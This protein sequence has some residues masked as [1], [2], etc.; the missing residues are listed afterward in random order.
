MTRTLCLWILIVF[1]CSLSGS[2]QTPRTYELFVPSNDYREADRLFQLGSF[3]KARALFTRIAQENPGTT[4]AAESLFQVA[5]INAWAYRSRPDAI[6]TYQRVIQQF[7]LSRFEIRARRYIVNANF[8]FQ[9]EPDLWL[10]KLDEIVARFGAPTIREITR[11]RSYEN[12]SERIAGLPSEIQLGLLSVYTAAEGTCGFGLQRYDE[13][14]ALGLFIRQSFTVDDDNRYRATAL[15][16]L[17]LA[18]MNKNFGS[19]VRTQVPIINP[20]IERRRPR[21]GHRISSRRPKFWVIITDG[22]YLQPQVDL[23]ALQFKLNGQDLKP[24]MKIES[25]IDRK[26]KRG[27]V[28]ERLKL[29]ARPAEPL[30]PG[31]YT[32]TVVAPVHGYKGTGPGIATMSWSFVIVAKPGGNDEDDDGEDCR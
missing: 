9:K 27:E 12:Y 6:A 15:S 3:E 7:P 28:F 10:S 25:K 5:K 21:H 4:L 30:A 31:P 14:I 17:R 1:L 23:S 24:V 2:A 11:A 22:D 32:L 8:D 16:Q 20:T 26:L 13:A 18:L 19:D 29:T